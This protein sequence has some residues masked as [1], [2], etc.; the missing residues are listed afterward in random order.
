LKYDTT[1]QK[2][3]GVSYC[4]FAMIRWSGHPGLKIRFMESV[5]MAV[6][7]AAGLCLFFA[8]NPQDSDKK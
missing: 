1:L 8:K 3:L 5:L 2:A 7:F 6:L 4:L